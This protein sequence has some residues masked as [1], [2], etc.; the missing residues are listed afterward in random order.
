MKKNKNNNFKAPS[1]E[2][3][4]ILRPVS[5]Y[6][7]LL[8]RVSG[9]LVVTGPVQCSNHN[10]SRCCPSPRWGRNGFIYGTGEMNRLMPCCGLSTLVPRYR[11]ARKTGPL[12]RP[13]AV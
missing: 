13:D 7:R 8:A 11:H 9:R 2:V 1:W 4:R 6:G 12:G 10:L 5:S 3:L